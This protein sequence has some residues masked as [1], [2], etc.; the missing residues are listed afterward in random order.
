[1]AAM[2]VNSMASAD[3]FAR[4]AVEF[5]LRKVLFM[6][7]HNGRHSSPVEPSGDH[8]RLCDRCLQEVQEG[9]GEF[10]EVQIQAVAD[11]TP[12]VLDALDHQTPY[13]QLE[14]YQEIVS[15]TEGLSACEA[16]DQVYRRVTLSLCNRCFSKWIEDPVGTG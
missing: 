6:E 14:S 15:A 10:F 3:Q 8:S 9:V 16:Q 1:M 2:S 4:C 11:P 12:P 7:N 5:L 13:Q